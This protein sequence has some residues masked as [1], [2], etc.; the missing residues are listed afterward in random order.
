MTQR[1]TGCIF[2]SSK[3]DLQGV[4]HKKDTFNVTYKKDTFNVTYKK[5]TPPYYGGYEKN[6]D[7]QIFE[8]ARF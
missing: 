6:D 1:Y 2:D 8:I 7:F 4:T 5:D 3:I